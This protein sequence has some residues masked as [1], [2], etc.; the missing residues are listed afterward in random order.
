MFLL[1]ED[2][3]LDGLVAVVFDRLD[4]E[5]RVRFGQD[6]GHGRDDPG[7]VIDAGHSYLLS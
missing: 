6:D 3:D 4:L 7:L 1:V 2:A 5:D